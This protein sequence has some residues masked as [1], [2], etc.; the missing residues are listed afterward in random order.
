MERK[1]GL[2]QAKIAA[3][4]RISQARVTQIMKLL[5]LPDEIQNGLQHPPPPLEI[6]SLSERY[7][8]QIV[9]C[10]NRESQ[11]RRWQELVREHRILV[12]M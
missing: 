7:L 11:L 9:A 5:E 8:R 3:R 12:R 1:T 2:T 4:E 10:G 6:S